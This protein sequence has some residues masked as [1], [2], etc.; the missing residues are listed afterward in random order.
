MWSASSSQSGHT[1]SP[2][3]TRL[4]LLR[5]ITNSLKT[6]EDS[7]LLNRGHILSVLMSTAAT[8]LIDAVLFHAILDVLFKAVNYKSTDDI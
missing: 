2:T 6:K 4:W 5:L 7:L 3:K 1:L 8:P